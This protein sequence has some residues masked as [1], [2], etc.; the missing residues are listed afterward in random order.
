MEMGSIFGKKNL[1]ESLAGFGPEAIIAIVILAGIT[2]VIMGLIAVTWGILTFLGVFLMIMAMIILVLNRGATEKG[3]PMG[4]MFLL[5]ISLGGIFVGLGMLG[6]GQN[7]IVDL[8]VIP[9]MQLLHN[10]VGLV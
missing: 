6:V 7:M 10:L 5:A 2:L 9:G 4:W 1:I 3:G 8:R